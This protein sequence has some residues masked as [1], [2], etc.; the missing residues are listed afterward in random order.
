MPAQVQPV[1]KALC[2]YLVSRRFLEI[3]DYLFRAGNL[4]SLRFSYNI[5]FF[6]KNKSV[7]TFCLK[8]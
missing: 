8:I 6:I 7:D 2:P 3:E 1:R 4:F 5:F